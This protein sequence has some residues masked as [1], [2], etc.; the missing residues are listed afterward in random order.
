MTIECK[1]LQHYFESLSLDCSETL[2]DKRGECPGFWSALT[3][4]YLLWIRYRSE[5]LFSSK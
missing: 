3:Y 2:T 5:H 4:E 1:G